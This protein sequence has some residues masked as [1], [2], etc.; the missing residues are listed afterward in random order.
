MPTPF[1]DSNVILRHVLGDNLEQSA[2][3]TAL[4]QRIERGELRVRTADTGVFEVVFTLQQ[5][6]R[7]PKMRIRDAILPLL[8]LP[9]ISLPGKRRFRRAFQY[10]VDLNLPFADA[11]HAALMQQN[12]LDQILTF[13]RHFDRV[14]GVRRIE[15]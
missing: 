9:G 2:R 11:Y 12:R 5:F 7:E 8:E 4:L 6:Y 10:Y 1:L 15:P 14:P 3:A 13:D